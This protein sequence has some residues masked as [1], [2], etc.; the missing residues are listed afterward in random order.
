MQNHGSGYQFVGE[1][2]DGTIQATNDT[3]KIGRESIIDCKLFSSDTITL[4]GVYLY[5]QGKVK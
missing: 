2:T 1:P 3:K 4:R 5:T